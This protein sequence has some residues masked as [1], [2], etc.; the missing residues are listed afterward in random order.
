MISIGGKPVLQR[1]IELLA[2]AGIADVV[3]N[4]HYRGEAIEQY[5]GD[6]GAFGVRIEYSHEAALLGT[7]GAVRPAA[8]RL[9]NDDFIVVYG[10]NLSTIDVRALVAF[11]R[12]RRADLTMALYRRDDASASGIAEV[13]D[14]GRIRRFL[15]KPPADGIFSAWVNA[16]YF[17]VGSSVLDAIPPEGPSDFGHDVIPSLIARDRRIFGYRMT[18]GLWWIDTMA[19]YERTQAE[20]ARE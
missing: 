1:N 8:E 18:E 19:D 13:D 2:R 10:D 15:E 20:F 9:G 17:V 5:F 3:I 16:G 4:T 6:G 7:A 11:H 14:D 12:D